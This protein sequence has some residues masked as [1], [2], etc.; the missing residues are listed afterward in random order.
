MRPAVSI[1]IPPLRFYPVPAVCWPFGIFFALTAGW[2]W[3]TG[4]GALSPGFWKLWTA[5]SAVFL[6]GAIYG[7]VRRRQLQIAMSLRELGVA[8]VSGGRKTYAIR[9]SDID[10]LTVSDFIRGDERRNAV[11]L[12]RSITIHADRKIQADYVALPQGDPLDPLLD[13]LTARIA[14]Q[15]R[16]RDGRGW[17]IERETLIAGGEGVPMSAI[18]SAGVFDKEVRLWRRGEDFPFLSVPYFSRN[19][20]VLLRMATDASKRAPLH[21]TVSGVATADASGIGRVLFTRRTSPFSQLFLTAAILGALWVFLLAVDKNAPEFHQLARGAA[22]GLAVLSLL[23]MIHRLSTRYRFHERALV[24]A[25]LLGNRTLMYRDIEAMSW[26]Q[27]VTLVEHAI[28]A[29][30]SLKVNLR[31]SDGSPQLKLRLYRFRGEDRDLERVRDVIAK[32]IAHQ[33]YEQVRQGRR[34][35]WTKSATFAVDALEIRKQRLPYGQPLQLHAGRDGYLVLYRD[36]IRK[37]LG[38]L[39]TSGP[40]FYP[41]LMLFDM[42]ARGSAASATWASA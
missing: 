32:S 24:R 16:Q 11:A 14:A 1:G 27:S 36:T 4:R 20:R 23:G 25:T 34:V 3:A 9:Y 8:I 5:F 22:L 41:G 28:Y 13:E 33:M 31:P 30:T 26:S 37:P 19:A 6:F 42:L 38:M 10:A 15:P 29:G 18:A 7:M 35:P 12:T 21:A 2:G 40:N 17:T 39:R